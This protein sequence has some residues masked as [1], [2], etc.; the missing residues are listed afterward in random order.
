MSETRN[1]VA[2]AL[3]EVDRAIADGSA[4]WDRMTPSPDRSR[5]WKVVNELMGRRDELEG[6]LDQ[7]PPDPPAQ[8]DVVGQ[9]EAIARENERIA[10]RLPHVTQVLERIGELLG[11]A[12]KITAQVK[13]LAA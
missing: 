2:Q 8:D 10:K 11:Q 13:K 9:L 1:A 5:L 3:N 12:A 4:E 7:L 6:L